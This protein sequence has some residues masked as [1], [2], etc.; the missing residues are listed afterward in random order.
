[1]KTGDIVI[2]KCSVAS[3]KEIGLTSSQLAYFYIHLLE[4]VKETKPATP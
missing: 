1:M 2:F 4:A 3:L